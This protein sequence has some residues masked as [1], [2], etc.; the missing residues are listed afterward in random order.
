MVISFTYTMLS[1]QSDATNEVRFSIEKFIENTEGTADYTDLYDQIENLL[2][3]PININIATFETLLKIPLITPAKANTLIFHRTNYGN[4]Q[5]IYELQQLEG[6]DI[7]YIKLIL[8]FITINEI[9][10]LK[11]FSKKEFWKNGQH[12]LIAMGACKMERAKGYTLPDSNPNAYQGNPIREV[13]RYKGIFNNHLQLNITTEK[14]AGEAINFNRLFL[15][16]GLLLKDMGKLKTL[17]IG[18]YQAAFGQGLTFGSGLAFGKSPFVLNMMRTQNGLRTYRSLNENEFLRG[19]G[20]SVLLHKQIELTAFYSGKKIDGTAASDSAFIGDGFSSLVNTG[21]HRNINEIN[22]QSQLGRHIIG[23]HLT[24]QIKGFEFGFTFTKTFFNQNIIAAQKP[25]QHYNFNGNRI[26]N[27][28]TDYKWFYKNFVLY[29]EFSF[30]E[31]MKN[32]SSV[33]GLLI[34]LGKNLDLSLLHRHYAVSYQSSITNAIGEGSDNRNENGF[35]AGMSLVPTKGF[36]LNAYADL[37]KFNWY[38]YL[39]DAP[40]GGKDILLELQY[41]KR[42]SYSWYLRYRSENK[43]KNEE[44]TQMLNRMESNERTLWRFHIENIISNT[45]SLRNRIEY[46]QYKLQ[47][48]KTTRGF[49]MFQDIIMSPSRKIKVIGRLM[50][51]DVQDYD[52]RLYAYENDMLYSYSVPAFQNRGTRFYILLKYKLKRNIDIWTRFA[53]TAYENISESGNGYDLINGNKVSELKI[54]VKW[55][56]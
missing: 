31:K 12:E 14:D 19:I 44:G 5:A 56:L 8:P 47:Y 21:Y 13:M 50:Y 53:R 37:Y 49:L 17:A 9:D 28:G 18:D 30:N 29:G 4:F 26:T 20:A 54:Q 6:F 48:G 3:N 41:S 35:Y 27:M 1:A 10:N 16:G 25:Y 34:S 24:S 51:F 7:E 38:R 23:G 40:S 36:K 55:T 15:S 42:K 11:T 39:V 22:K 2:K 45:F 32:S 52:A 46:V 33:N 43:Q